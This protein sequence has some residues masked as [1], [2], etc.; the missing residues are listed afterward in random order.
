MRKVLMFFVLVIF[1]TSQAA[2]GQ[3]VEEW[4]V[5]LHEPHMYNDMPYRLMKPLNF[6]SKKK[7]PLIV[8]LHGGGGRG[9]DNLKQLRD[10]NEVLAYEERRADYPTYVLAP[11]SEGRWDSTHLQKIKDIINE[12]PAVDK[13]RIYL[14][15]HSMGAGGTYTFIRTDPDYFAAAAPSA[16]GGFRNYS[17]APAVVKDLPIWTFHGDQDKVVPIEGD[18]KLFAEM[19]KIDGNMKFTTWVGDGHGVA[20]K[21]IAG[22]ENGNTQLSSDQCD[23]EPVFMKWL[24]AQKLTKRRR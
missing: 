18:Q 20:P 6:D 10:W 19:Q 2:M 21:M 14:L 9:S 16:G 12:L 15:G 4:V 1:C 22:G 23:T 3:A 8:S 13:N 11:Q 7:Y 17:G 24:F 5:Q